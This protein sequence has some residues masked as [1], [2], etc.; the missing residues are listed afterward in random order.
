MFTFGRDTFFQMYDAAFAALSPAVSP[1][2]WNN[3]RVYSQPAV[4]RSP[5]WLSS[6]V[7]P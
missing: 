4:P 7:T 2:Y 1:A 5:A 6:T 3:V